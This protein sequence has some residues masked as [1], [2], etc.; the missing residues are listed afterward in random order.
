MKERDL[1]RRFVDFMLSREFQED[2]PLQ[3][4]VYPTNRKASLPGLFTAFAPVPPAP[5]SLDA[6][7]IDAHRDEW[8]ARWTKLVLR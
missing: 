8:I 7:L 2:I 6:A 4:F 5:A 1:A 3:M